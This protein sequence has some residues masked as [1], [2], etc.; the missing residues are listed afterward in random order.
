[1][2]MRA[3]PAVKRL[4][5]GLGFV[6]GPVAAGAQTGTIVGVATARETGTPLP[7]VDVTHMESGRAT[8]GGADGRFVL[9][10]LPPGPAHLRVRRVG[11]TPVTIEVNVT[12]RGTDTVR[13][14]LSVL[15]LRLREVR[16]ANFTCGRRADGVGDTSVV[17]ILGQVQ[18]NAER[19]RLMAQESP[20]ELVL[21]RRIGDEDADKAG[22]AR[23]PRL[24]IDTKR[25]DTLTVSSDREW[26]YA[27]GNIVARL[28]SPMEGATE[29]MMVP[30]LADFADDAFVAAHCFRYAGLDAF[31]DRRAIRVDFEPAR[32]VPKPDV[33][34]SIYLDTAS[35]QIIGSRLSL[36]RVAPNNNRMIWVT[37]VKSWFREGERGAV[38]IDFIEQWTVGR[39]AD[40][41]GSASTSAATESQRLLSV[42]F[43]TPQPEP[44]A[45]RR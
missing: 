6:L 45:Q 30:Q 17:A 21:E 25:I 2:Q 13:V 3:P 32:G 40:A 14:A 24:L 9:R 31:D 4:I 23:R 27:P 39:P 29:K 37:T 22:R 28:D 41:R 38:V 19:A 16:V 43:L 18:Q 20:Y 42:R 26:R 1:M 8:F 5:A 34:G 35:Y 7:T 44:A 15:A 33:S 36:E 10:G 12:A 11:F